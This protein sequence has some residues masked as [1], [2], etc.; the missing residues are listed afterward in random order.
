MH[1]DDALW[2]TRQIIWL[3]WFW[4]IANNYRSS[5]LAVMIIIFNEF[6]YFQNSSCESWRFC[7]SY[8]LNFTLILHSFHNLSIS[9][10][11][12]IYFS[13]YWQSYPNYMPQFMW[14]NMTP[15]FY[16]TL[17]PTRTTL[18]QC[19]NMPS[20]SSPNMSV[21]VWW[22]QSSLFETQGTILCQPREA[23][24]PT[25]VV[26]LEKEHSSAESSQH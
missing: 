17:Y 24:L 4:R 21:E 14:S 25:E 13:F 12:C 26:A 15:Q 3:N 10:W 8:C 11:T 18:N 22:G 20:F 2:I 16:P 1:H 9:C 6:K 19:I 5:S 23:I 7:F